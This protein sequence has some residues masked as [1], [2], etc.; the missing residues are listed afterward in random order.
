MTNP[1]TPSPVGN[2]A[3]K[4]RVSRPMP[5]FPTVPPLPAENMPAVAVVP[6]QPKAKA[7]GRTYRIS[8]YLSEDAG[9]RLIRLVAHVKATKGRRHGAPEVIEQALLMLERQLGL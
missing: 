5:V 2:A 7:A 1:R 9:A 4:L 3:E 6:V 8:T